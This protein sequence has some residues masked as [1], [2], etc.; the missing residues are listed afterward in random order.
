MSELPDGPLVAWYGD[1]FTGAAAT[2]EAMTF[3]GL[4]A[5]VFFV[6]PTPAMLARF[7]H[8]R[9]IG[10]AGSARSE[11]PKWMRANLPDIFRSLAAIGAPLLQYKICSTLDS[12]PAIGSIGAAMEIAREVL[13]A[14]T[15][16]IFPA[17]PPM[18]RYQAFGNLFASAPSGT[19]RLDRHPIMARHPVT[20]MDEA[21]VAMHLSRQTTLPISNLSLTD[22]H[23]ENGSSSL[24]AREHNGPK[25]ITI[26]AVTA[27]DLIAVGK[28]IWEA[29]GRHLFCAASQG[30]Q[31]ALLAYWHSNGLLPAPP[32]GLSVGHAGPIAVVSGSVSPTTQVQIGHAENAGFIVLPVAAESL[33][34]ESEETVATAVHR[35]VALVNSGKDVLLCT[36]RGHNDPAVARFTTWK[37]QQALPTS[38]VNRR[39]GGGLGEILFRIIQGTGLRRAVISGGD[40]SGHAAR[41]LGLFALTA[42]APTIP[43]AALCLAHA[44]NPKVDGLQLALKGG[45]MGTSDYFSWI[46]EGAGLRT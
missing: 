15:F 30:L 41:R 34:E 13:G 37:A 44:D 10:I 42:L 22:L 45:Q 19:F 2:M 36:A 33:A 32:A 6:S 7:P 35:A 5:V 14:D 3:G 27:A 18:G 4:P 24:V 39:V 1:D 8:M 17:A 40:T 46:R 9:G 29:R 16:P 31:Y 21:D 23:R 38:E 25:G 43:G 11:T 26:D 20:P 12:S 28:M